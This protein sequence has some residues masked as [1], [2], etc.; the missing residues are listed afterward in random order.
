MIDV[1]GGGEFICA[2]GWEPDAVLPD[3]AVLNLIVWVNIGVD[4][5]LTFSQ[6]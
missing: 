6:S 1:K 3:W 2:S 4:K 5:I